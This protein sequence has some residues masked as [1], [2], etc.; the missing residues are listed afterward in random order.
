MQDAVTFTVP[1][2]KTLRQAL[3]AKA[4]DE[5]KYLNHGMEPALD[6]TSGT[7]SL[8]EE[9]VFLL[10]TAP[11]VSPAEAAQEALGEHEGYDYYAEAFRL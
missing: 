2:G 3:G 5:L 7:A 1:S 10:E 8:D 6:I 9:E 4:Y 11:H